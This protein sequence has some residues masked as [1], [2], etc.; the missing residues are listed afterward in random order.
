M[1]VFPENS[2]LCPLSDRHLKRWC[3]YLQTPLSSSE[4]EEAD[5]V[6]GGAQLSRECPF[7]PSHTSFLSCKMDSTELFLFLGQSQ[8][9]ATI[10]EIILKTQYSFIAFPT[11]ASGVPSL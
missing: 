11:A 3:G 1:L 8:K 6:P 4:V 2:V 9:N 7:F 10:S 5:A